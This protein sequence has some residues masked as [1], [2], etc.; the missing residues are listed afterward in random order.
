MIGIQRPTPSYRMEQV[1][2]RLKELNIYDKINFEITDLR[3]K[4][5]LAFLF[6]RFKPKYCVHLASQSSVKKSFEYEE[7]TNESNVVISK[8]I[9]DTIE[10]FSKE[11]I[12]FF[13]S[14]AT[15]FEGYKDI[16]VNERTTQTQRLI[17]QEQNIKL[18]NIFKKR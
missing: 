12:F 2:Y 3:D 13:P 8:N 14:S 16:Q 4:N 6:K 9:I 17:T 7:L 11:T 18:K 5:N 10:E 1:T 15:I